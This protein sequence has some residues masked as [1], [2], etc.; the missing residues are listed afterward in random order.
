LD[1]TGF[2]Y[3]LHMRRERLSPDGVEKAIVQQAG[4]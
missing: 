4:D 3:I 1:A 2:Y